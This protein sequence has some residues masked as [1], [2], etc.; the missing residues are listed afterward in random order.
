MPERN[1][2]CPCGSGKKY[3]KCCGAPSAD[4]I[5]LPAYQPEDRRAVL[6][7][8]ERFSDGAEFMP[9]LAAAFGIAMAPLLA[10]PESRRQFPGEY[11]QAISDAA[12]S[13][14]IFDDGGPTAPPLAQLFIECHGE[15]LTPAQR[16]YLDRM[17]DSVFDVVEVVDATPGVGIVV[18]DLVAH[19]EIEIEERAASHQLKPGMTFAARIMTG[20][21]AIAHMDGTPL[22]FTAL[23]ADRL[24][25]SWSPKQSIRERSL[26]ICAAFVQSMLPPDMRTAT[27]E[28]L[29]PQTL[30]YDVLDLRKLRAALRKELDMFEIDRDR[31][32]YF[33]GEDSIAVLEIE[34]A[35]LR[36][37]VL[38]D[39]AASQTR[40]L[41]DD[42]KGGILAY[43]ATSHVGG[44]APPSEPPSPEQITIIEELRRDYYQGWLDTAIPALDGK[45][46]RAAAKD[47]RTR[48]TLLALIADLQTHENAHPIAGGKPADYTWMY[49]ELGL[50]SRA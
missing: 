44:N 16:R 49:A 4:V 48:P 46:P 7:A 39:A 32:D 28:P 34:R 38:S 6:R 26:N 20:P 17:L 2:P 36:A 25:R 31:F 24:S 40:A 1:A 50:S 37:N 14:L 12:R 18:I 23:T 42:F 43:K 9:L 33:I 30:V 22:V 19:T 21:R 27:G 47:T 41:L 15:T 8:L 13:A 5:Q 11:A 29:A 35:S 10:Q 3:K 45:T